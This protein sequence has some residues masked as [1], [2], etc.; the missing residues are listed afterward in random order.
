MFAAIA[1]TVLGKP[2]YVLAAWIV[3]MGVIIVATPDLD[4]HSTG[5]QAA[6]LPDDFESVTAQSIGSDAFPQSSGASGSLV[7]SRVDGG[8]LTTADQQQAQQLAE[9]LGDGSVAGVASA[10]MGPQSLSKDGRLAVI[11]VAFTGQP[12]DEDVDTAV[13]QVRNTADY[14]LR[15][16]DL[17]SGLT[18]NAA[19]L[20][21][22]ASAYD[23]AENIITIATV[24]VIIVLLGI[25]FRSLLIAVLPLLLI[26][27]VYTAAR[28]LTA[29]AAALFDFQV[30]SSL[31]AI[32]VVVLFGVGTDYIVFLLFRY[33]EEMRAGRKG[34]EAIERSVSIVGEVV[35]SSALT[36]VGAFAVLSVAKLGSLWTMAPGLVISVLLMLVTALTAVPALFAILGRQLFW[37]WG[38]REPGPDRVSEG[39]A[40][41]VSTRPLVIV[42]VIIAILAVFTAF[43]PGYKPTYDTLGELP[44]D[45][46]SQQAYD[47]M[48]ESFPQGAL[49]PTQ[50]YFVAGAPMNQQQMQ[51]AHDEL[52]AV[53]DVASVSAPTVTPD[54]TRALFTVILDEN[55]YGSAALDLIDGPLRD[56]V[57]SALPGVDG[58]V[59]G[60]T[61]SLAE[62]RDQLRSDTRHVFPA[63]LAVVLVILGVL[64]LAILAPL[65]L[66]ACVA[67]TFSATM[68]LVVLIFQDALSLPGVDAST[69]IVLYLFVVAIG[70]DYNILIASRLREEFKHGRSPRDAAFRAV[71]HDVATVAVAGTILALTFASL[72]LTG[73]DNLVE[74]GAGVAVGVLL[75]SLAVAP[76][77]VPSLSI[78]SG[79]WFWWPTRAGTPADAADDDLVDRSGG[80]SDSA[81]TRE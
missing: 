11:A 40:H 58:Y 41:T 81:S 59:G 26:G 57:H 38:L 77:V 44:S 37:P 27:I 4:D 24:L 71:R 17:T 47:L 79:R 19:I 35:A 6:F 29:A 80:Q 34:H 68:G 63:A 52:A 9:R 53:P 75:A 76:L 31:D 5:N 42:V 55:P 51:T 10:T 22:T 65:S 2:W 60:Q 70:T 50:V 43:A 15:G 16:G 3:A 69:P 18:G 64:L 66:L 61:A 14:Q 39:V 67:L 28:G 12:G 13:G 36:V 25:A 49:S 1:R 7:V 54:G 21:D 48:A 56:A 46:P 20:V 8:P 45:T 23:S 32:L 78:F 72:M 62:V 74:L 73:L 33:R 30:S